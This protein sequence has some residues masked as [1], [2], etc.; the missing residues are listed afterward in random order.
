MKTTLTFMIGLCAVVSQP[1]QARFSDLVCDDT[2][3]LQQQLQTVV[4][5]E[6]QAQG[7]RDP[8]AMIEIWIVPSSGDWT[9]VQNYANGTSCVVAMGEHWESVQPEPT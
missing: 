5:A 7:L 3:R 9:I 4:G 1:A 6:Q 2:S 8:E